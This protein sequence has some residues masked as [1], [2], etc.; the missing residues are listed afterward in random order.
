MRSSGRRGRWGESALA[1]YLPPEARSLAGR[2]L[3]H[4]APVIRVADFLKDQKVHRSPSA[5]ESPAVSVILPTFARYSSGTLA[6]AVESVLQQS[7]GDLELLVVDDGSTDGTA[8]YLRALQVRDERLVHVRHDL[9]SGL[10]ALRVNEGIELARGRF[11]AFQFDDD[12]WLPGAL[13]ALVERALG[14]A[15]PAVVFGSAEVVLASGERRVP[16]PA[17]PLDEVLLSFQNRL[18]NNSVLIARSAFDRVGMYD[19]QVAMRRLCD[20]DLWMRLVRHIPFEA[21][22]RVVSRVALRQDGRAIS[23]LAPFDLSAFRF[24]QAIDR[25][26]LLTPATWHSYELDSLAPGGVPLPPQIAARVARTQVTPF[27]DRVGDGLGAG[28]VSREPTSEVAIGPRPLLWTSDAYYAPWAFFL[29]GYDQASSGRGGYKTY[30]QPVTQVEDGWDREADLVLLVRSIT[31]PAVRLAERALASRMPLGYF[32]DDDLLH[33]HELGAAWDRLAPGRPDRES[34]LRQLRA[35]DA[36]WTNPHLAKV[37]ETENP[38]SVPHDAAVADA[39]LPRVLRPRGESGRIRIGYVGGSYRREEFELLWGALRD[40]AE[41]YGDTLEFEFWGID[42]E[43]LPPL[44]ALVRTRPFDASMDRFL[45]RLKAARFDIL[46]TPLLGEP[47]PRMAKS[48]SKYLLTAVAGALGIF[49]DISPYGALP[50]G[51]SCLK[52]ENRVEGWLAALREGVSMSSARFDA[53]REAMIAHVRAEST[54]EVLVDLHEAA[55]RAIEVHALSRGC[56]GRD[57]RPRISLAGFEGSARSRDRELPRLIERY[58]ISVS[59]AE[60]EGPLHQDEPA[61]WVISRAGGLPW[62]SEIAPAPAIGGVE[63]SDGLVPDPVPLEYFSAGLA[64][65]LRDIAGAGETAGGI[66]PGRCRLAL[67]VRPET[68]PWSHSRDG[69]AG[70][71]EIENWRCVSIRGLPSGERLAEA[72]VVLC[73]ND[74][75]PEWVADCAA[76]AAVPFRSIAPNEPSAAK[77][78]EAAIRRFLEDP[79]ETVSRRMVAY[80][81]V[82]ARRHP[83][84]VANRLFGEL[85]RSS[86]RLGDRPSTEDGVPDDGARVSLRTPEASTPLAEGTSRT[87]RHG[88]FDVDRV[89]H[90]ADRVGVYRPLSRLRWSLRRKRVLVLY[91]TLTVS[92]HLYYGHALDRLSLATGREW[93]IRSTQDQSPEDLYSFHAVIFQRAVSAKA[94]ELLEVAKRQGCHTIYDADDNLLLIDQVIED[95]LHPWRVHFGEARDRITALLA[96]VDQVK[97]YSPTAVASFAGINSRVT[98]VRPYHILDGSESPPPARE[99]PARIGFLGSYYKDA[100]FKPVLEAILPMLEESYPLEFEFFGFCPAALDRHPGIKRI[101]W[102]AD[103]AEF[104]RTLRERRWDVGLAPL[105]DLEFNRCKTDIRYR[106]YV[107]AGIAAIV[108]DAPIYRDGVDH[109]RTGLVVPQEQPQ[110]WREAIL[111]LAENPFLRRWL[112]RQALENLKERHRI[113]NYVEAVRAI[114]G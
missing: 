86:A 9:N 60:T 96:G 35:A 4:N 93:L 109:R 53:M 92:T 95:P 17:V 54:T 98:V 90:L 40:L 85:I 58:G 37:I 107:A 104:R 15:E 41:E 57:G 21:L 89:R 42:L 22:D 44:P 3:G 31:E 43:D 6:R 19:C 100:E 84:V 83:Q 47:R 111:E 30:Y 77:H 72:D 8:G 71:L 67:W 56:R 36:V 7:W 27:L 88:W 26:R 78:L 97:V 99:G 46:L 108:S 52:S 102:T 55:C 91:D 16:L 11:V 50:S 48:P 32:L 105:R 45:A 13:K 75:D 66:E 110:A 33:L 94:V 114:I 113:E 28:S 59:G 49:S 65:L 24:I 87:E 62:G 70:A 5:P 14:L 80:R 112:A 39:D 73:G 106:E 23:L 10:P 76:A 103:Y 12:E 51:V 1:F 101:P 68:G 64:R 2:H 20:W 69:D 82:R 74:A 81:G 79:P 61:A 63:L 38:R 29:R 34:F 18:A 25:D